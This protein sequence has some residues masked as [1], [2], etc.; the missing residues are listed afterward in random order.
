MLPAPYAPQAFYD[1]MKA[2]PGFDPAWFVPA[3]GGEPR[4]GLRVNLLKCAPEPFLEI[5]RRSLPGCVLSPLPFAE[6]GFSVSGELSGRSP[7]HHAGLFYMQEP[8]AMAA[9][10]A[11]QIEPGMKV[12]DLCAAPGGKSTQAAARL[13]GRGLL[14]SNEIVPSR[15]KIL[16]SNIERMGVRNGAVLCDTPQNVCTRLAGFFD[17]V[18][19][20][21]PCSGEGMFRR[22]PMAAKEWRPELPAACAKRQLAILQSARR[23]VKENGVLVYSTCTFSPEEN[24]GV[25][26]AFLAE[27]PDF[28]L[29]P[30]RAPFGRPAFPA[31]AQAPQDLALA[32]R[33]F[34]ADGGEGH[35]VARLRRSAGASA[36][37]AGLY[38]VRP[39]GAADEK[40]WRAFYE[41]QFQCAPFGEAAAAG[42]CVYLL[43]PEL[44][45]L[46]GLRVLRA[47]VAAGR[48]KNGRV[49]PEHALYMAAAGK[50][51]R[52]SVDFAPDSWEIA[53]FLHGEEVTVPESAQA[54]YAAVLTGGFAV[55]F[56]K[57]SGQTAKNHYPKGLRNL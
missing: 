31:W 51:F 33:I 36:S 28:S 14:V 10:T 30:I 20:D 41:Q 50:S 8:S 22:E 11:A 52:S 7:L 2:L 23:A 45:D 21:A 46:T 48:M 34:P 6:E 19:V 17:V 5:A 37:A 12:L 4:R 25:L 49:L 15:A 27:N 47:G 39:L 9:V 54:G 32:R 24:E 29:E 35:F 56:C 55:G 57:I 18:L 40:I 43:P 38:P 42:D 13:G 26:A 16:L 1:K 44:P 3:G 53:A